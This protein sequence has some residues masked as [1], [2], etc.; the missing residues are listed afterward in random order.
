MKTQTINAPAHGVDTSFMHDLVEVLRDTLAAHHEL[1]H[2]ERTKREAIIARDAKKLKEAVSAQAQELYLIDLL[3]TRRKKLIRQ[4]FESD[5]LRLDEIIESAF[6]TSAEKIE[7][8]RY[9]DALK[10]AL[11][12]LKLI[13]E[14]NAAMLVD[15]RDLF[16]TMVETLTKKSDVGTHGNLSHVNSVTRPVLI[17]ANC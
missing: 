12:E 7:L 6:F 3:E 9:R 17:D 5:E 15:S 8:T 11:F 1:L 2:L 13:S 16:K 10:N 14:I 4:S